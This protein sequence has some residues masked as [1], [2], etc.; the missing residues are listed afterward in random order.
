[1]YY[2]QR[3]YSSN[4][5]GGQSSIPNFKYDGVLRSVVSDL[6]GNA[7]ANNG[8]LVTKSYNFTLPANITNANH[9]RLVA[10]VTDGSGKVL[11]AQTAKLGDSK[12]FENL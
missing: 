7:V 2:T 11:N 3:N 12:D 10:L 4:I 5:Y 8:T 9:L 6:G 1:M